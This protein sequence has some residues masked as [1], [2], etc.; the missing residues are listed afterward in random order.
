MAEQPEQGALGLGIAGVEFS[1]LGVEQVVEEAHVLSN[2]RLGSISPP[3]Q[4][5]TLPQQQLRPNQ[6]RHQ[7]KR[8]LNPAIAFLEREMGAE[9]TTQK[10]TRE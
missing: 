7:L 10:R 4:A 3:D 9:V 1:Y 6:N 2:F 5:F 8:A